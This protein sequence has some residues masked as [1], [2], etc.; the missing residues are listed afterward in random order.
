[1]STNIREIDYVGDPSNISIKVAYVPTHN[2]NKIT[3]MIDKV[4]AF[5]KIYTAPPTG[6]RDDFHD[7][8]ENCCRLFFIN[9][10]EDHFLGTVKGEHEL[11]AKYV[12]RTLRAVYAKSGM[13]VWSR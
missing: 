8:V 11:K 6:R 1:M 10:G 12:Y 13:K 7:F 2:G 4:V 9:V 3:F 5:E